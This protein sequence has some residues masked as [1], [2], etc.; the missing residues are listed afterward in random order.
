MIMTVV[1]KQEVPLAWKMGWKTDQGE[2]VQENSKE[3]DLYQ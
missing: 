1:K 3:N 2:N